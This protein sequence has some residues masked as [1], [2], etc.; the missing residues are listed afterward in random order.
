VTDHR[1]VVTSSVSAVELPHHVRGDKGETLDL[2]L[3]G[4][5]LVT[6]GL[7]QLPLAR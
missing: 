4:R 2:D 5:Q 1:D 7:L 3:L 6:S